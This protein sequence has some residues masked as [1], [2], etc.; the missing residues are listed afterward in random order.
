MLTSIFT[1]G[2]LI[3]E[4]DNPYRNF[5]DIFNSLYFSVITLT[6]VGYGDFTPISPLGR[7]YSLIMMILGII[8]INMINFTFVS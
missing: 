6:T 1:I 3:L 4:K 5:N 8:N 7:I 2:I